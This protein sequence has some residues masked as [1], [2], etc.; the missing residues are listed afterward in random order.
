MLQQLARIKTGESNLYL[1]PLESA[2]SR[3]C[4][5]D[6]RLGE[7]SRYRPRQFACPPLRLRLSLQ[8]KT[9]DSSCRNIWSTVLASKVQRDRALT[10]S[11]YVLTICGVTEGAWG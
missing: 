8:L 11:L 5:C 6:S 1:I 3:V 4:K 7:I 10:P 2:A 9:H